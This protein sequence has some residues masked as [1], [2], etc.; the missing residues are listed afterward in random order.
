MALFGAL[1]IIASGSMLCKMDVSMIGLDSGRLA[2]VEAI[3]DQKVFHIENTCF[4]SVDKV[5]MNNHIYSDKPLFLS[6]CAAQFCKL[7]TVFTGKNFTNSYSFMVYLMAMI[8]GAGINAL[9]FYWLFRY[10]CRTSRG[11]MRLK[12]LFSLLCCC[13]SW[14]LSYMTIFLN[15]VPAALAAAGVMISLDKYSRRKDLRAAACA[16]VSSGVLFA[17]DYV[18]GAI[19]LAGAVAAVWLSAEKTK[20]LKAAVRCAAA[21]MCIVLFSVVLNYAAYGTIIPLYL[22]SGGTF[23]P[24]TGDKNYALYLTEILFTSRGLFSYQPFLLL[25]FP[26]VYAMRR[27]L[28]AHDT[29]LLVSSIAVIVSYAVLTNEYGGGAYGFR[30]LICIIPVLWYYAAKYVLESR[31]IRLTAAAL[32]LG[33]IGVVTA[34]AGAYEP[35]CVTFEGAKNPSGHFTERMRTPFASNL[36]AWSYENDPDSYLT[37]K[38]I[39]HYGKRDSFLYLRAQYLITKHFRTLENLLKD[40]RFDLKKISK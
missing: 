38:L 23:T 24:G 5:V 15:H 28:K 3:A 13:G 34:L 22:V 2:M 30:Y 8:F 18:S 37:E 11:N 21:G 25:V 31:N 32:L 20:R 4:K 27:K 16:G 7:F 1:L 35:L 19:F 12:F 17:L 29:V 9:L 10:L 6:W 39:D 36:L 26:A 14:L 33:A 40:D